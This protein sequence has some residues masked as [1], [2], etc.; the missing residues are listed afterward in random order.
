MSKL[1]NNKMD[2]KCGRGCG[3]LSF[4]VG[5][6]ANCYNHSGAQAGKFSKC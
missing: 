1:N 6:I 3:E 4:T 2:N 5:S